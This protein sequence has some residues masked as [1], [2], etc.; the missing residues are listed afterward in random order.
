MSVLWIVLGAA[1][2]LAVV[3]GVGLLVLIKLGVIAKYALKEEPPDYGVYDLD[4]SQ[5]SGE[6]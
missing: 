4:Q 2:A 6:K 5:E 1:L 3:G